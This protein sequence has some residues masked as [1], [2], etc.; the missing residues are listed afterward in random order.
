MVAAAGLGVKG[1]KGGGASGSL[2]FIMGESPGL[3]G[4]KWETFVNP[5]VTIL[6]L[7]AAFLF[8]W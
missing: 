1:S 5:A 7:V 8:E 3:P 6:L 2:A 4:N